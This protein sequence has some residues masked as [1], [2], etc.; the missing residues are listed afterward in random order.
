MDTTLPPRR[1]PLAGGAPL[2]HECSSRG[3]PC[4]LCGFWGSGWMWPVRWSLGWPTAGASWGC[5]LGVP[6]GGDHWG[7]QLVAGCGSCC[8]GRGERPGAPAGATG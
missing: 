8:V 4:C 1:S 2:G 3:R 6:A 7:C 5:P